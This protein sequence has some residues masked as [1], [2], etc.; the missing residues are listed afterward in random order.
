MIKKKKKINQQ[1]HDV[2]KKHNSVTPNPRSTNDLCQAQAQY[3][4]F[5]KAHK[6]PKHKLRPNIKRM[7]LKYKWYS[8]SPATDMG[9]QSRSYCSSTQVLEQCPAELN[10]NKQRGTKQSIPSFPAQAHTTQ[11]KINLY[12]LHLRWL[13]AKNAI[14]LE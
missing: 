3:L 5:D 8:K 13:D 4:T 12:Y 1:K 9:K 7:E 6:A 2:V 14:M 10:H 11:I